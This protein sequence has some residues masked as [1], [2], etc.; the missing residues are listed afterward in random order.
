VKFAPKDAYAPEPVVLTPNQER[1]AALVADHDEVKAE[2]ATITERVG[3]LNAARAEVDSVNGELNAMNAREQDEMLKWAL[4]DDGTP[5][6]S[7]DTTRRQELVVALARA[8]AKANAIDGATRS[9]HSQSVATHERL[10][11]LTPLIA[12]MNALMELDDLEL[13]LPKMVAAVAEI[14]R[15]K[16]VI[17]TGFTR[18]A[19]SAMALPDEL[20]RPVSAALENFDKLKLKAGA[21]MAPDESEV[22]PAPPLDPVAEWKRVQEMVA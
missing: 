2:I 14:E 9:L 17:N 8:T 4:A 12:Q 10:A 13:E 22:P 11:R 16:H 18:I 1:R 6:P 21:V 20:R 15:C 5:A 7:P 3:R 19:I